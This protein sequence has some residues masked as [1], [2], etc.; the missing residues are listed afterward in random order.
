MLIRRLALMVLLGTTA[1]CGPPPKDPAVQTYERFVAAV[2]GRSGVGVWRLLSPSSQRTLA[3]RL[4]LA[5]DA[6][7][8]QVTETMGLRPGWQFELDLPQQARL[9]PLAGEAER[10]VVVGPLGGRTLKIPM[11]RVDGLWRIDLFA[12]SP[13]A[14]EGGD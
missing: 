4:G 6:T 13:T 5:P 1:A 9:E 2:R 11:S 7:E 10:R 3:E 12:A 14:D 8:A